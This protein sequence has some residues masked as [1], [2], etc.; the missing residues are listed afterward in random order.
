MKSY[1]VVL[2]WSA[3]ALAASPAAVAVPPSFSDHTGVS[4]LANTHASL[5]FNNSQYSGGASIGDFNNDGWQDVFVIKGGASGQIDRLFINNGDGTFT[6]QAAAWGL[7]TAHRGKATAVGDF[8]NDGWLD[9]FVGSAGVWSQSVSAGQN[10]LYRNNG[11]GTFTDIAVS[12]GV[13]VPAVGTQGAWSAAFGDYDLDGD[14]DLFHGGW[15]NNSSAAS[16][17]LFRNNGDETFTDVTV[18]SGVFQIAKPVAALS[19]AF[20][21]MNG[22]RYPELLVGGDFGS[23]GTFAGSRYYRNNGDGTFTDLTASSGT[24]V[25]DNGMGQT[26]GDFDRD[27][28]LEWYVTSIQGLGNDI[29]RLYRNNGN[30]S[31]TEF[32]ALA[33]VGNGGYGWGAIATDLNHDGHLDLAA[34]NEDAGTPGPQTTRLWI[35]NGDVTFTE[36]SAATGL[37]KGSSGRGILHFDSDNDGDPDVLVTVNQGPLSFFRNTTAA[38]PQTNWVRVFLDTSLPDAPGNSG[39]APNGYGSVVKVTTGGVTQMRQITG[40]NS[41]LGISELS[42]H[43]GLGEATTIDLLTVI[44]ADGT[45]TRLTDVAANQTLTLERFPAP[46][47]PGDLNNDAIVD[48]ADLGLLL[49]AWGDC[50]IDDP[51]G[52]DING[53]GVVDGADLGLLLASWS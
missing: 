15:V 32:A 47:T 53:D 12:A 22:D 36:S 16:N 28:D 19:A 46:V 18:S 21:D 9:L 50:P 41:Y 38:G 6:D 39:L 23:T 42:A 10:K 45:M 25:E 5:G 49:A 3:L 37:V 11:N 2:A 31:Y 20:A 1:P 44:W 34:T 48:G 30:D 33:G 52:A 14:L 4:G 8:N 26:L 24:N 40:G 17:R 7:T 27:G 51:C 13:H 43:F 35:N 29:S